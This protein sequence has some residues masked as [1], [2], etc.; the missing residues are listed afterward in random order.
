[1]FKTNK[2]IPIGIAN[3]N[4]IIK[5]SICKKEKT[6][7]IPQFVAMINKIETIVFPSKGDCLYLIPTSKNFITVT[8]IS[9]I[10]VEITIP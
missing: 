2:I 7:I 3:K 5:L 4:Q 9:E 10:S 1:M 8:K 6:N